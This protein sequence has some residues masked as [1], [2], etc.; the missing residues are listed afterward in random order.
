MRD[1]GLR[2][3]HFYKYV[4]VV[5]LTRGISKEVN[6]KQSTG[7]MYVVEVR[8]I[9]LKCKASNCIFDVDN[10]DN[11]IKSPGELIFILV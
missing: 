7:S 8:N 6:S 4:N 11:G 1:P 5:T 2:I 3:G 9:V 10:H